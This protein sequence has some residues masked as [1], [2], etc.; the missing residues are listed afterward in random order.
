VSN[1]LIQIGRVPLIPDPDVAIKASQVFSSS[2]AQTQQVV[3]LGRAYGGLLANVRNGIRRFGDMLERAIQIRNLST[4]SDKALAD[5]GVR[6][7]QLS[8]LYVG[9][10]FD[11]IVGQRPSASFN[12]RE[13]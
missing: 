12:D 5:I 6:R 11:D 3:E 7:D 10:G 8:Q 4:M 9:S 2:R 1:R 13:R